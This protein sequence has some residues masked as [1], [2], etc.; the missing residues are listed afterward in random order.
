MD[1]DRHLYIINTSDELNNVI[2]GHAEFAKE[3]GFIP[4]FV[5]PW[6]ND[7][8]RFNDYGNYGTLRLNFV[9]K[10]TNSLSYLI[11]LKNLKVSKLII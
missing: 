11:I 5:F 2:L 9:F 3:A 10:N 1:I 4:I 7:D 6:R 8:G